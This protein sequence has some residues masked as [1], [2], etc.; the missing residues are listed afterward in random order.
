M[1]QD[2]RGFLKFHA[3]NDHLLNLTTNAYS[4]Q[5]LDSLIPVMLDWMKEQECS[6]TN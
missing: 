4:D 6:N 3:F 1:M 2:Y 5:K